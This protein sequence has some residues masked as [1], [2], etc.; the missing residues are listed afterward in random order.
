MTRDRTKR[1]YDLHSWVGITCGLFIYVVSLSGVFALFGDEL[2]SWEDESLRI[3]LPEEPYPADALIERLL[4]A[5]AEDGEI[6]S[7]SLALPTA[8]QPVYE[9]SLLLRRHEDGAFVHHEQRW[10][11][12]TGNELPE[13]RHG[14]VL[15]I[16]DFHRNLMLPR[17]L[18]R[19]LVGLS[20][21]LLLVL[22]FSGI[23]THRKL[24]REAFTW[25]L[26]RSVR[27]KW[28]DSHK[29]LG[30]WGLPFNLM[31]AFTGAW[32]GLI[33]LLLPLAAAVAFKGD[34]GAVIAAVSAPPPEPSGVSAP[35]TSIDA[36]RRAV[37]QRVGIAPDSVDIQLWGDSQAVYGF[38]YRPNDMLVSHAKVDVG[39]TTGRIVTL[40]RAGRPGLTHR[41]PPAITTLHYADFGGLWMKGLYTLLGLFLC[42]VTAT[43]MMMWLERRL[44]GNEGRRPAWQYR[45]LGRS[46]AGICCGMAL[47]TFAV[48]H[49]D[50]IVAV[51]PE[52]RLGMI[53]TVYFAVWSAALLYALL[54]AN[55]YRT[56]KE[57]LV[58]ALI[59]LTNALAGGHHLIQL[60]G[61]G[62][63]YAGGTDLA[64]MA[65]GL[66]LLAIAWRIPGRRPGGR[67]AAALTAARE[68]A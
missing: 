10:H 47:T 59:P 15:W 46:V 25:R 63:L 12:A 42:V 23:I 57:V 51:T 31:I 50:K 2:S 1:N 65:S 53:G 19:A 58:A 39:A 62:H 45:L 9:G 17:T 3:V 61:E 38:H 44:H 67:K 52:E 35:M 11:P 8:A 30:L 66:A 32:L 64:A 28:Q 37:A 55:V 22:L 13:H 41:I 6:I 68:S 24:I 4:A 26:D 36:A 48:F 5:T 49:A 14:L 20:G 18:G 34:A 27:L 54:R 16:V 33:I 56:C 7:L 40:T 21:V 60:L 43:G 29:A